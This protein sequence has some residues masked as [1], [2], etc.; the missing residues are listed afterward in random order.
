[1]RRDCEFFSLT[2]TP[3]NSHHQTKLHHGQFAIETVKEHPYMKIIREAVL[4][5]R[6]QSAAHFDVDVRVEQA[7]QFLPNHSDWATDP[8]FKIKVK[9]TDYN[10][11]ETYTC[12]RKFRT[13]H[14]KNTMVPR[15]QIMVVGSGRPMSLNNFLKTKFP[16]RVEEKVC[17][18]TMRGWWA[19]NG[20]QFNWAGL[21]TELKE[22]VVSHCLYRTSRG[23]YEE[24][25]RRYKSRMQPHVG[26]I[27]EFG[28]FEIVDKLGDWASLL[29]V[30]HQVR[31]IALRLCFVEGS[32]MAYNKGFCIF[33]KSSR[34]LQ[35]TLS[36]LG[37]YYQLMAVDGIPVD[38]K[39]QALADCYKYYPK[40]YKHLDHYAT[41]S[42]GIRRVCMTM[43]F[44]ELMRFFKVTVG[45]FERY[46]K[47]GSISFEIFDRLP[48]LAE[49]FI[50]LPGKPRGG[51][52]NTFCRG[53]FLFHEDAPCIRALHGLIYERIAASLTLYSH[54][55]V[56]GFID[57]DEKVRFLS[58][59]EAAMQEAKWTVEEFEEL[60]VEC[61][62]GIQL[63][64]AVTP[65]VWL[66][67]AEEEDTT[68]VTA[69]YEM[70][71]Y[72]R[73]NDYFP[74]KCECEEKCLVLFYGRRLH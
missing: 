53:P 16:A 20:K 72:E 43:D 47:P 64:E 37:R 19:Q 73:T 4:R 59:R 25:L 11:P 71:G 61:G 23:H 27:R 22:L 29:A 1:M 32:E 65:A 70:A 5:Y 28:T 15:N 36:R 30:S 13:D 74:P 41:F 57:G 24:T 42:H 58:L 12:R 26:T 66:D 40:I 48:N 54:V 8:S 34:A 38:D 35:T 63:H 18:E 49:I 55:K 10:G 9:F 62:G 14:N 44:F 60:Y 69:E 46:I 6:L 50:E 51:W 45:G 17:I 52:D 68:E 21:P 7:L 33:T 31:A 3:I 56:R 39:S 67:K 2:N